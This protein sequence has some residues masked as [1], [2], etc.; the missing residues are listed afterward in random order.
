MMVG[1]IYRNIIFIQLSISLLSLLGS[2]IDNI[3]VGKFLSAE[4]LAACGLV[5]PVIGLGSILSGVITTGIKT[6]CS[7]SIGAGKRQQANDQISTAALFSLIAFTLICI[8]CYVF[9]DQIAHG[10]AGSAD[11]QFIQYVKDYMMG[12]LLVFPSLGIMSLFIY[13]LQMNNKIYY[14]VNMCDTSSCIVNCIYSS[15]S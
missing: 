4:E 2:N 7:R 6:V 15:I 9:I 3:I 8:L 12:Y 1:K 5:A 10:L 11:A 14:Q 13:I